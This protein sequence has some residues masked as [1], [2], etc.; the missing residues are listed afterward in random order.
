M[1]RRC[2]VRSSASWTRDFSLDA[3]TSFT[4]AGLSTL[5]VVGDASPLSSSTKFSLDPGKSFASLTMADAAD[6]VRT[7][8]GASITSLLAG[9]LGGVFD[10]AI[11][12]NGLLSLTV[13]NNTGSTMTGRLSAGSYVNVAAVPLADAFA[14][15]YGNAVAAPVPE[16]TAVFTMLAGLALVASWDESLTA[17]GDWIETT[18]GRLRGGK[19]RYRVTRRRAPVEAPQ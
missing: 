2:E 17:D 4:F 5:D 8:I 3:N 6:R 10:Y 16:P 1:T 7:S 14:H 9:G 19:M 18:T 15:A 13:T 12:P 11:G